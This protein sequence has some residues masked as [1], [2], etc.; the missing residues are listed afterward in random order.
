[1][2]CIFSQVTFAAALSLAVAGWAIADEPKKGQEKPKPAAKEEE[3][4]LAELEKMFV[5]PDTDQAEDYVKFLDRIM[6]YRPNTDEEAQMYNR[7]KPLALKK[8]ADKIVKLEKDTKSDGYRRASGILV[9]AEANELLQ[10]LAQTEDG[11]PEEKL[12]ALVEKMAKFLS[13]GEPGEEEADLAK[14]LAEAFE[15]LNK[16]E[17]ARVTYQTLSKPIAA[18]KEP[19]IAIKGAR[20]AGIAHRMGLKG[21]LVE[22]DGKTAEGKEF[23]IAS[24]RGKVVLVDFWATWCGPCIQEHPNIAKNYEAYKEKGFE[25]VGISL[26]TEKEKLTEHLENEHIKWI[27]LYEDGAGWDSKLA[28]KFGIEGIPTMMLLDKD[29][30]LVT[31]S[32]RGPEL[33][34][35]LAALLGPADE[36]KEEPKDEEKKKQKNE[37]SDK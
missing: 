15:N 25:V 5:L 24:L 21:K 22:I 26:D 17:L 19:A 7:K 28:V 12:K 37:D 13:L 29:G 2:R 18:S 8:A 6:K 30:K 31:M 23:D 20:M 1:M 3:D 14:G 35:Q 9:V 27:T 4:S 36:K 32:A 34:K 16:S 33:G 11:V 10:K